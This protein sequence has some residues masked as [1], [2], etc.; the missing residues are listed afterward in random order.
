M[1]SNTLVLP[2]PL[3]PTRKLKSA[4]NARSADSI[5]RKSRISRRDKAIAL[6]THWHYN[7][8][9]RLAGTIFDLYAGDAIGQQQTDIFTFQRVQYVEHVADV[10]AD[11]HFSA[12]IGDV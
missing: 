2:L 5:L 7:I 12:L 10:K 6:Q 1:A 8:G 11:F 4:A 3:A 9:R